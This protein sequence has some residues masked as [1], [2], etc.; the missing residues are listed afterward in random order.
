MVLLMSHRQ[1]RTPR[2][3][4]RGARF[5]RKVAPPGSSAQTP[6]QPFE[7]ASRPQM[8]WQGFLKQ[9]LIHRENADTRHLDASLSMIGLSVTET[10]SLRVF[11]P[12]SHRALPTA[13]GSRTITAAG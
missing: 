11:T 1:C 13:V 9:L 2:C 4:S 8:C 12:A 5:F 7:H 3:V 6:Q 10:T